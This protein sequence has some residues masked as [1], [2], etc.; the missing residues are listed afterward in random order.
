MIHY[1]V[2]V[3]G[4]WGDKAVGHCIIPDNQW[5]PAITGKLNGTGKSDEWASTFEKK[6]D[7]QATLDGLIRY[8]V[9]PKKNKPP[10]DRD[11]KFRIAE[12]NK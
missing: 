3:L 12:V 8:V 10:T 9:K 5:R 11:P 4:E 7:A 2:Q 6:E 1:Q